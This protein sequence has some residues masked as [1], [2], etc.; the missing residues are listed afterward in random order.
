VKYLKLL[1]S[2]VLLSFEKESVQFVTETC[3]VVYEMAS[4]EEVIKIDSRYKDYKIPNIKL[5]RHIFKQEYFK[6]VAEFY[7]RTNALFCSLLFHKKS[8]CDSEE[9]S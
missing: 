8:K 1:R 3:S 9:T 7:F 2:H 4:T 5:A 6:Q